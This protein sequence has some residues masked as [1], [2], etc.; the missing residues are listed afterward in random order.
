[1]SKKE[2]KEMTF[3]EAAQYIAKHPLEIDPE[4][5]NVKEAEE[6]RL[7][8]FHVLMDAAKTII[9]IKTDSGVMHIDYSQDIGTLMNGDDVSSDENGQRYYGIHALASAMARMA[10]GMVDDDYDIEQVMHYVMDAFKRSFEY[11]LGIAMEVGCGDNLPC[12]DQ[13]SLDAS[14]ES[15]FL[16]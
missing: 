2:K 8:A 16:S 10:K 14:D 7:I 5:D 11:E 4:T 9:N 6:A 15:H 12:I 3:V 1:M 13:S